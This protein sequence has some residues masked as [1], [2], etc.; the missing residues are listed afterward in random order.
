[1]NTTELN[2]EVSLMESFR[3]NIILNTDSYKNSHHL[4]LPPGTTKM[5]SYGEAR[6]G[7]HP[8][9][10]FFGL[11]MYLKEYLTVR[12]TH[13]MVDYAKVFWTKHMPGVPFNEKDWRTIVDELDGKLL[14]KSE[15]SLKEQLFL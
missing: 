14:L 7:E 8:E 2:R 12:V 10:V 13:E 9:T 6:G 15:Q 1:M 11:Q 4:Q 3:R 5:V